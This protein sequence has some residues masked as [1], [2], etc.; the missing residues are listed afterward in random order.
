MIKT[1]KANNRTANN[2]TGVITLP[3][4]VA[5]NA[6]D[7]VDQNNGGAIRL[8]TGIAAIANG[9]KGIVNIENLPSNKD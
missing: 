9:F 8:Y 4:Q 3:I 1:S 5:I 2:R 7:M 6:P